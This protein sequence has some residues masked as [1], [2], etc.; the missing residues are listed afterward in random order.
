MQLLL[1]CHNAPG[2]VRTALTGKP[3]GEVNWLDPVLSDLR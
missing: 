1:L 2:V 3:E